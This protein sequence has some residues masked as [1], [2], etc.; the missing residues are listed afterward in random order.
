MALNKTTA[1]VTNIPD[2]SVA[3]KN[4]NTTGGIR[5]YIDTATA[6]VITQTNADSRY[7][8]AGSSSL[9]SN[10]TLNGNLTI[11]GLLT[12]NTVASS[13]AHAVRKDYVDGITITQRSISDAT[14]LKLTGGEL[15]GALTV[16]NLTIDGGYVTLSTATPTGNQAVSVAAMTTIIDNRVNGLMS[17]SEADQRYVQPGG[18]PTFSSATIGT[19]LNVSGFANLSSVNVAGTLT[20]GQGSSDS[21]AAQRGWVQSKLDEITGDIDGQIGDIDLNFTPN[22]VMVTNSAGDL[23]PSTIY[24]DQFAG[25]FGGTG[26]IGTYAMVRM[27]A[28]TAQTIDGSSNSVSGASLA[29]GGISGSSIVSS[30]GQLA[31]YWKILGTLTTSATDAGVTLAQRVS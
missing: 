26:G 5:A 24:A 18:S 3:L 9:S 11:T 4:D 14:Y 2:I 23:A 15:E 30:G 28:G 20:I 13:P 8:N 7:L 17:E 27:A 21:H 12:L 10:D 19:T 16:P 31:G 6:G 25:T 1:T 22:R 29:Y